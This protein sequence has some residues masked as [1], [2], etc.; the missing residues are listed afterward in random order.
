M[1]ARG[2]YQYQNLY[3][4]VIENCKLTSFNAAVDFHHANIYIIGLIFFQARFFYYGRRPLTDGTRNISC[5]SRP[6]NIHL[7]HYLESTTTETTQYFAK[8]NLENFDKSI[9][10]LAASSCP[11]VLSKQSILQNQQS[12]K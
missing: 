2:Q 4:D 5:A 9:A 11:S 10:K 1:I 12:E 6:K 8:A 7:T 3:K